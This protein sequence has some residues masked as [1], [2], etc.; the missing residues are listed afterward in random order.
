MLSLQTQIG[1]WP[2]RVAIV[3]GGAT[4]ALT[5]A[6]LKRRLDRP[7][8]M[9]IEPGEAIGR[10]LAYSTSDPRHLLNV[11]V[12][13]MS[14]FSDEPGHLHDWLRRRAGEDCPT[15]FCFISRS[16]Y[17]DYVSELA[18]EALKS[19]AARHLR[20]A[21]VDLIEGRDS[22]RLNLKSGGWLEAD[23][24]ILAVGH[25]AKPA[26]DAFA[27]RPWVEGSLDGIEPDAPVLI[28]G[29]GL[30]MVDMALALDRRGHRGAITAVSRRGLLPTAHRLTAPRTLSFSEVPFGAEISALLA[31][32]RGLA[33]RVSA[34]GSD[35]RSAIDSVRPYTQRLWRSVYSP[36][37]L[38]AGFQ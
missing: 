13:N 37:P 28:V 31:W 30:T 24:V 17:G 34:E 15:P 25:D 7:V 22:V 9:L 20:D 8:V 36:L 11:R 33:A 2:M 27:A 5:A 6:H 26:S 19:G 12:S 3:G 1:I 18:Q 10:G 23:R 14:A 35:W 29:S 32:L 16:T 38:F 4:G 21:C